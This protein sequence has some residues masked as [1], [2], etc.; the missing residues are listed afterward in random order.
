MPLPLEHLGRLGPGD[1]RVKIGVVDG[2]PDLAIAALRDAPIAVEATMRIAEAHRPDAHGT[3]I[4]SLLFDAA[5]GIAAGC[6][7][8]VLPVFFPDPRPS[9]EAPRATQTDIAR[10]IYMAV[11]RG[12]SIVNVS[13]G[14]LSSTAEA[15]RHLEDALKLCERSGVLVVAAAGNDGCACLHVPAAV[16]TVLAVGAMDEDGRP[17]ASSNYG[18]GYGVNGVLAPGVVADLATV[19]GERVS[20]SGSSFATAVVS[21][22]AAR[23]L[24]AARR[25]GAGVGPLD[26]RDIIIG[27]ARPCDPQ[28]DGEC[29]RVLAGRLDV[30]AAIAR[31]RETTDAARDERP[32]PGREGQDQET[33]REP[34]IRDPM[35]IRPSTAAMLPPG[36]SPGLAAVVQSDC[37]CGCGGKKKKARQQQDPEDG[38]DDMSEAGVSAEALEALGGLGGLGDDAVDDDDDETAGAAAALQS[39]RP[40]LPASGRLPGRI[41]QAAERAAVTQQACGCG[42][43]RE[44]QK[45]YAL[46]SVWFDFGNEARYDAIVQRMGDPVAANTPTALI[47]MLSN[48][49]SFATG[50]TFILMQDQIPI[51]AI[52]PAGPFAQEVYRDLLDAMRTSL[53]NTGDLQRV[54]LPGYVH[55]STRLMNGMILPVIYP[56]PRGMAKWTAPQL[57]TAAKAAIGE[58]SIDEE[59]IFNFLVRVYDELRNL[60]ISPEE[61]AINFAATNA[62]QGASVFADG[63]RRGLELYGI[64]VTKSPICRPDSDCWDVQ[65]SM[66]DAENER[67]A[68]RVYRFTVDVSEVLPVTVGAGRSW[69]VPLSAL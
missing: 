61:R 59:P 62:Y 54:A 28:A 64:R 39:A 68:G 7:G 60:G 56:D 21:G 36:R 34:M 38:V 58:E 3:E 50:I 63:M 53:D 65:V 10:A 19:G 49:L 32:P 15:S 52:T 55:G 1:P 6:S 14:Q 24:S 37:G 25:A 43:S 69:S 46:G 17:L 51:Y 42:G 40:R 30:A 26:I 67:R 18:A 41:V 48:D 57:V 9:H 47:D 66:F 11:E 20:R 2:P 23:M 45:V 5:N 33:G 44:P 31:L 16:A 4:C 29:A 27:T 8:L 35:S 22:V 13:A 12:V